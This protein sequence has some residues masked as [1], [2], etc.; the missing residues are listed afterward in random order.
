MIS[1]AKVVPVERRGNGRTSARGNGTLQ[2]V[3]GA[4]EIVGERNGKN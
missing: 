1:K 4:R 3:E 2:E